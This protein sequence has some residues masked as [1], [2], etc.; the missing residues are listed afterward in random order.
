M[1]DYRSPLSTDDLLSV[2]RAHPILSSISAGVYS[3]DALDALTVAGR[4]RFLIYNQSPAWLAPGSHWVAIWLRAD[5][6]GEVFSS[7]GDRP[8]QP[9]VLRFVRRHCS[10]GI[11]SSVPVQAGQSNCCG[12]Y[13]LSYA[14]ERARGTTL[15][16]WLSQFT[17]NRDANDN[18]VTCHF[19]THLAFP[20][21]F[22]TRL[23][24]RLAVSRVCADGGGMGGSGSMAK[25][26]RRRR[27]TRSKRL[28]S[29][30]LVPARSHDA[31]T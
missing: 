13:C 25:P 30:R 14:Y 15:E 7:L 29:V 1:R 2:I 28:Q 20:G 12:I 31:A 4:P 16:R 9:E 23:N 11:Y 10:Q 5:T 27:R 3:L 6:C 8:N 26:T 24:W 21:L 22:S 18:R 19:M 17:S